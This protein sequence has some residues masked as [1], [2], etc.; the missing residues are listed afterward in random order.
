MF[1]WIFIAFRFWICDWLASILDFTALRRLFWSIAFIIP[2]TGTLGE[3]TRGEEAVDATAAASLT[4]LALRQHP[5]SS[6]GGQVGTKTSGLV[7]MIRASAVLPG[8]SQYQKGPGWLYG[9]RS[10][11]MAGAESEAVADGNNGRR[12]SMRDGGCGGGCVVV[13]VVHRALQSKSCN[14]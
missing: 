8:S 5:A 11:T 12:R 9:R 14:F 1:R 13:V 6:V 4:A 10:A 7:T 2:V 3:G